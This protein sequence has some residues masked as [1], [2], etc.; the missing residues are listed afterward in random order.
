MGRMVTQ[1]GFHFAVVRTHL[2]RDYATLLPNMLDELNYA[3][4]KV[5]PS[6]ETR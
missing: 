3:F 5:I 1:N 4:E 2:A 6:A